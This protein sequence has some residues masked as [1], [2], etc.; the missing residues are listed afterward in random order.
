VLDVAGDISLFGAFEAESLGCEVDVVDMSDLDY[1]RG[2]R[3]TLD[4]ATR[5]RLRL[6]P[7]TR[8]EDL[9]SD[10]SYDAI[11]CIS[12]IEHFD[13]DADLRFVEGAARLLEP[14]GE[15]AITAPFTRAPETA[16]MYRDDTY[17][18]A[19]GESQTDARFYMRHY[20]Q[21]GIDALARR[22]GLVRERVLYAGEVVNFYDTV[23]QR[24]VRQDGNRVVARL[25]GWLY[26]AVGALSP[27][28]PFLFMREADSMEPFRLNARRRRIYDP[29]TYL[30]VLRK[31][32]A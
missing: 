16:L 20:S 4:P 10:R 23:F 11:V 28:W 24:G 14:G 22:S 21:A 5:E 29:D 15:M 26:R 2:L 31:P 7:R 12:S 27:V 19:H 3:D 32:Y 25:R 17:Y 30:L 1:C 13:G 18:G 8:A 6:L 9:P